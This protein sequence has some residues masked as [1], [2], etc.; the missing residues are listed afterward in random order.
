MFLPVFLLFTGVPALELYILFKVGAQFGAL[1]TILIIIGTGILGAALAKSQGLQ[2]INNVQKELNEGKIPANEI[3]QGFCVFG[4]GL[5]LLTPGFVTDILGFCMIL[6]GPRNFM[7]FM[8]K[9][10]F[11]R[12]VKSG[13]VHFSFFS[14]VSGY[15]FKNPNNANDV[16]DAEFK[17]TQDDVEIDAINVEYKKDDE[18]KL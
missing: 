15:N 16:F 8:L 5:L 14:N 6:P 4:G 1:N 2:L 7:A 13:N 10:W 12:A 18:E 3:I 9:K 11:E 17:H